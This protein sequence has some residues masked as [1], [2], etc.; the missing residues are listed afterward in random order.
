MRAGSTATHWGRY[1]VVVEDTKVV[2]VEPALSDPDPSPSNVADREPILINTDDAAARGIAAGDVVRVFNERG[3]YL[4]GA[5]ASEAIRP[6]VVQLATGAWYDPDEPGVT[7]ALDRHGN[8]NVLTLDKGTSKLAHGPSP[9]TTLVGV[10][11]LEGNPPP[12]G[13]FTPP[14]IVRS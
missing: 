6:G 9:L 11:R 12:V 3:A 5:V 13:A 7:G 8:P 10:E 2:A 4:A 1:E 14:D